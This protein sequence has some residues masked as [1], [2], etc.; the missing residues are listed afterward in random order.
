ML[1]TSLIIFLI[2]CNAP[3]SQYAHGYLHY[4]CLGGGLALIT[5]AQSDVAAVGLSAPNAM[6]SRETFDP[7][8]TEEQ[9]NTHTLN[10]VPVGDLIPKLDDKANLFQNIECRADANDIFGCHSST[11]SLCEIMYTCGSAGRPVVC[12]C[13]ADYDYPE[14]IPTGNQTNFTQACIEA[15]AKMEEEV[16]EMES[17][18]TTGS[19]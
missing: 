14:P 5:G 4:L 12:N 11:R 7:P 17:T 9:L 3:I 15:A 18:F 19:R 6:L 13:T 2:S 1:F 10:I 8:L 16:E